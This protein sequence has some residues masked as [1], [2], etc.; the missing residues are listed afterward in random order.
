M[1]RLVDAEF[2][3]AARGDKVEK[4]AEVV[5]KFGIDL[6]CNAADFFNVWV[7]VGDEEFV[8]EAD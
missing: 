3:I 6:S 4:R 1:N 5:E 7:V 2:P 8:V